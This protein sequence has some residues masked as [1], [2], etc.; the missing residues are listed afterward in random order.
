MQDVEVPVENRVG[1]EGEGF[2]VAMFALEN[3]R[4][5][6]AAGATGLDPRLPRRLGRATP[7]AA[8]PSACRSASTSS[9]R[10]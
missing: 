7:R 4:Y 2:K 6:V 10:R 9:S 3:G 5:T 1:E 8:R